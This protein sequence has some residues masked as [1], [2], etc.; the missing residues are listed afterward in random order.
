MPASRDESLMAPIV[1]GLGQQIAQ[2]LRND[3]TAGRLREG[4]PLREVE[5]SK[6]FGTSRGP[7]RD[8]LLELTMEGMLVTQRRGGVAVAPAAGDEIRKLVTPIRQTIESYAL[9][10]VFDSLTTADFAHWQSQIEQMYLACRRGDH[11]RVAEADIAFHRSILERSGD[12]CLMAIWS[13]IVGQLRRHFIESCRQYSDLLDYHAEHVA[14]VDAF[15]SGDR[16]RAIQAL[17]NH[18]RW[19]M[20][21]NAAAEPRSDAS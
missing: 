17:E 18:I 8:A 11:A 12:H 5:L 16:T 7:I 1:R 2:E 19:P 13:T 9:G 20:R 14:L 15:H 6:R 4:D 10:T 21:Q 3:I